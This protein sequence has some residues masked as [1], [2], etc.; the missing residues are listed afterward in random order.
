MVLVERRQAP[1]AVPRGSRRRDAAGAREAECE[2]ARERLEK[3]AQL[4]EARA[5]ASEWPS[6]PLLGEII[7]VGERA[8]RSRPPSKA[9]ERVS[10]ST[11]I[12][13]ETCRLAGC[14]HCASTPTITGDGP[15]ETSRLT[16]LKQARSRG[17]SH[18]RRALPSWM[19]R[20]RHRSRTHQHREARWSSPVA[21]EQTD[22]REPR[23]SDPR[24]ERRLHARRLPLLRQ[25]GETVSEDAANPRAA[26]VDRHQARRQSLRA[27]A[28]ARL[29]A[30]SHLA[31][32]SGR[33]KPSRELEQ[34]RRGGDEHQRLPRAGRKA[35]RDRRV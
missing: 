25:A 17:R 24:A 1:Q 23:G 13:E 21:G 35:R 28:S 10:S 30:D 29:L 2:E 18:G 4:I 22:Y 3:E 34:E 32:P 9:A 31:A 16:A 27:R 8:D 26:R 5:S 15:L 12:P 19:P 11:A 20:E 7:S 33:P 14:G 6:P